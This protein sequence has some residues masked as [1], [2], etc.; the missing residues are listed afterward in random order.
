MQVITS[1]SKTYKSLDLST[2][3]PKRQAGKPCSYCYV[4]CA[5]QNGFRA[6]T[7]EDKIS[8][9]HEILRLKKDTIEKLNDMG[10]LRLF[11]FG[12][13]MDWMDQSLMDIFKDAKEVG[14]K[15]KA[16]TKQPSFVEKFH[17]YLDTIN[18]SVDNLGEGMDINVAKDLKNKYDNVKVR[19]AIMEEKDLDDLSWV[20][21]LTLNHAHN[22]YHFF[23]PTEKAAIAEK[24]PDKLCCQTNH[25]ETCK[26]KCGA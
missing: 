13:Y 14:L 25:C 16:I 3:C 18:V 20:D 24:Y 19:A 21:I 22:Q 17:E 9:D 1:N 6:K 2:N 23:T 12:D 11:S 15:L 10:G 5:R 4:E 7:I 26:V 8:Y